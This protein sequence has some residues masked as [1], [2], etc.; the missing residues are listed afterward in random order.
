MK[1]KGVNALEQH[2]EQIVLVAV[3]GVF[4]IVLALQFL[5]EPNRVKIGNRE[6]APGQAFSAAEDK[7]K[8]LKSRIEQREPREL[9]EARA[10]I[11]KMKLNLVDEFK[12]RMGSP[13]APGAPAVAYGRP[14][15]ID[16][17]GDPN[18]PTPG[19]GMPIAE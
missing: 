15:K 18:R 14:T 1:V 19:L 16:I 7:A 4:L 5:W 17:S 12:H 10:Q 2:L 11:D 8:N 6:V 9:E 3:A 13:L